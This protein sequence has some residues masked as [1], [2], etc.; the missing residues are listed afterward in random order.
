M[1]SIQ[2]KMV[3]AAQAC[4]DLLHSTLYSVSS[5]HLINKLSPFLYRKALLVSCQAALAVGSVDHFDL[6]RLGPEPAMQT[7]SKA[8]TEEV[9]H[10][11]CVV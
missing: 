10:S 3:L 1:C 11:S 6:E 5:E 2:S 7:C 8:S 4:H 9:I